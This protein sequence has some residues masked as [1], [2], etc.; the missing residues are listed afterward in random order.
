MLFKPKI[1]HQNEG[2]KAVLT[3]RLYTLKGKSSRVNKETEILSKY[4]A[5]I[6]RV[7]WLKPA[8]LRLN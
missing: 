6:H 1:P 2:R 8:I 3:Y 7:N 5:E 4:D